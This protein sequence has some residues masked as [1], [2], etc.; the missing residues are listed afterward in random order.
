MSLGLDC[1]AII[2]VNPVRISTSRREREGEGEEEKRALDTHTALAPRT[3]DAQSNAFHGLLQCQALTMSY[4]LFFCGA[5][6]YEYDFAP[7]WH[8][9]VSRAW[10]F[11]AR[12]ISAEVK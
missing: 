2:H 10:L 4:Q 7:R 6:C 3:L 9:A 1:S 12:Q 11:P 8:V 5:A